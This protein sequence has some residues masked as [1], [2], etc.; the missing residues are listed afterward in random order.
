MEWDTFLINLLQLI[1][2]DKHLTGVCLI[3]KQIVNIWQR[4]A[5]LL[6]R[7]WKRNTRDPVGRHTKGVIVLQMFSHLQ[8]L[9]RSFL[10]L[11][12]FY[13]SIVI[14]STAR[15]FEH[16]MF[17]LLKRIKYINLNVS[18]FSCRLDGCCHG[19]FYF[20]SSRRGW[21]PIDPAGFCR[22]IS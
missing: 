10:F 9:F 7:G 20:L 8:R 4:L 2:C 16:F 13:I 6:G 19:L 12:S 21:I 17:T 15:L 3:Q 22:D 14:S 1:S 5:D 18:R 11:S